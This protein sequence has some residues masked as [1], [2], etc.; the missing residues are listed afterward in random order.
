MLEVRLFELVASFC[1]FLFSKKVAKERGIGI[2]IIT[3]FSSI[4]LG[5]VD[6]EKRRFGGDDEGG[7]AHFTPKDRRPCNTQRFCHP[8]EPLG[9]LREKLQ[10]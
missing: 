6:G 10:R 9:E 7:T 3:F 1:F 2:Y 4:W 8:V 5:G